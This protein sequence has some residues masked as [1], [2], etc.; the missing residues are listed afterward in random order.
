[1]IRVTSSLITSL[2]GSSWADHHVV[3]AS[4][5]SRWFGCIDGRTWSLGVAPAHPLGIFEG[6]FDLLVAGSANDDG[7]FT[8]NGVR[9][10]LRDNG[11]GAVLCEPSD[12]PPP[13]PT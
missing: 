9:F 12:P 10:A 4:G 8:A 2:V 1:M 7:T 11:R 3:L 6:D 13:P 5:A